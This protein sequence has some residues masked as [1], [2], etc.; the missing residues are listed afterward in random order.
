MVPKIS[1]ALVLWARKL[2]GREASPSAGAVD[3][4]S[5]KRLIRVAMQGC[6]STARV[7]YVRKVPSRGVVD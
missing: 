1:H 6:A 7:I 2:P 4:K 3:R 5:L